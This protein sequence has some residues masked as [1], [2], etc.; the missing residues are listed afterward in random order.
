MVIYLH[1]MLYNLAISCVPG[2]AL[3]PLNVSTL[4]STSCILYNHGA[5]RGNIVKYA[6]RN[7]FYELAI[8]SVQSCIVA[9]WLWQQ[10]EVQIFS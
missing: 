1:K 4:T 5:T 8:N 7:I 9:I 10:D 3:A 6:T 2:D